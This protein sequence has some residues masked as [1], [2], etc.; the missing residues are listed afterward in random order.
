MAARQPFQR[1]RSYFSSTTKDSFPDPGMSPTKSYA[2]DRIAPVNSAPL[3]TS[4]NRAFFREFSLA[5]R[6]RNRGVSCRPPYPSPKYAT[7]DS[8]VTSSKASFVYHGLSPRTKSYAPQ[9]TFEANPAPLGTSTNRE[10]FKEFAYSKR[11]S[12][13]PPHPQPAMNAKVSTVTSARSSYVWHANG[14]PTKSYK[15]ERTYQPNL[16]PTGMS[17]TRAEHSDEHSVYGWNSPQK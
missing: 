15:P 17:T 2:P 9:R 7:K 4:T 11:A 1:G 16:A 13:R 12:F 5:S 6:Q 10:Y 8:S 14:S 3:E